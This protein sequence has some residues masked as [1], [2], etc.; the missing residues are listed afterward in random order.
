MGPINEMAECVLLTITGAVATDVAVRS[1]RKMGFRLVGCESN[2]REWRVGSMEV[3]VFYQAPRI[4]DSRA[5]LGFIRQVCLREHVSYVIPF[6]DTEVDLFSEN[7][8]WFDEH[9]IRLC[10]S[11]SETI[12]ILRNKKSLADF[13]AANCPEIR[14]IPTAYLR[15]TVMPEWDFPVVC[16]PCNGRSSNGLRYIRSRTEWMSFIRH[17]DMDTYIVEPF[18]SGPVVMVEVIR[19]PDTHKSV[20]MS[21]RELMSTPHG[22]STSVYIFRDGQLERNALVLADRLDIRGNVNFEYIMDPDGQYHFVECNPRFSAGCA[23]SC[24]GGY[25]IVKNHIRCFM[26]QDIDDYRFKGT[27]VIARRFEEVVTVAGTVVPYCD[28]VK[29]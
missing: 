16:K 4:S 19:Q 9:G 12:R 28:T 17:A 15:D 26:G 5:Y 18:I 24:L 7:R 21:R 14:H 29:N 11:G 13:I 27:M 8:E 20:A 23:F 10:I 3:D 25:D 1:L 2:P 22:L 6:L